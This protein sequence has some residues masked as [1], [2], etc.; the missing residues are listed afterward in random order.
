MKTKFSKFAFA[1]LALALGIGIMPKGQNLST[2]SYNY[3]QNIQNNN[4]PNPIDPDP[5][6]AQLDLSLF[7]NTVGNSLDSIQ[8]GI[9]GM[10]KSQKISKGLSIASFSFQLA[11]KIIVGALKAAG[12]IKDPTTEYLKAI[13]EIVQEINQQV[14]EINNKIDVLSGQLKK[15]F[16]KVGIEFAEQAIRTDLDILSNFDNNKLNTFVT[17]LQISINSMLNSFCDTGVYD[18]KASYVF[19]AALVINMDNATNKNITLDANIV[20]N[21]VMTVNSESGRINLDDPQAWFDKVLYKVYA[22]YLADPEKFAT[23]E[24]EYAREQR[25]D[26]GYKDETF[27]KALSNGFYSYLLNEFFTKICKQDDGAFVADLLSSYNDYC[28]GLN[29]LSSPVS[30]Q[31]DIIEHAFD[32]QGDT[33]Y[34]DSYGNERSLILDIGNFYMYNVVK[35]ASLALT[36][37]V[38]SG[39]CDTRTLN[40]I[41][42]DSRITTNNILSKMKAKYRVDKDG[43]PMDNYCYRLSCPVKVVDN[44]ITT[45][46]DENFVK[47]DN[48]TDK[49]DTVDLDGDSKGY[50]FG[51][52]VINKGDEGEMVGGEDLAYLS[53]LANDFHG[54]T[55][56]KDYLS[57]ILKKE[58]KTNIITSFDGV[59]DFAAKNKD[60]L[61]NVYQFGMPM[62]GRMAYQNPGESEG[63]EHYQMWINDSQYK[64][65]DY[66]LTDEDFLVHQQVS[67]SYFDVT[68]GEIM[69]D[70]SLYSMAFYYDKHSHKDDIGV[71][72]Q[73][74][75]AGGDFSEATT[76]NE[77]RFA[78]NVAGTVVYDDG[79]MVI[80]AKEAT[81]SGSRTK[82][83]WDIKFNALLQSVVKVTGDIYGEW[84]PTQAPSS[85]YFSSP[86][87]M[88]IQKAIDNYNEDKPEAAKLLPLDDFT[89]DAKYWIAYDSSEYD[90]EE[91]RE[92]LYDYAKELSNIQTLDNRYKAD[93][94]SFIEKFKAVNGGADEIVIDGGPSE[95]L[96]NVITSRIHFLE[97][98]GID[99]KGFEY[100]DA[101]CHSY[102]LSATPRYQVGEELKIAGAATDVVP[103]IY[104]SYVIMPSLSYTDGAGVAKRFELPIEVAS[105]LDTDNFEVNLP[106][107]K[108]DRSK[109]GVS[110]KYDEDVAEIGSNKEILTKEVSTLDDTDYFTVKVPNFAAF[111]LIEDAN[112][113]VYTDFEVEE[114]KSPTCQEAGFKACYKKNNLHYALPNE[115]SLINDY[116]AWKTGAGKLDKILH[117]GKVGG[118]TCAAD[119]T[120]TFTVK[121]EHCDYSETEDLN[122]IFVEDSPAN[123]TDPIKGH[124]ITFGRFTSGAFDNSVILAAKTELG[125]SDK[126]GSVPL[127]HNLQYRRIVSPTCTRAGIDEHYYCPDCK[128]Y[129]TDPDGANPVDP[130]TL[131]I[132]A[133]GHEMKYVPAKPATETEPGNTAYYYCTHCGGFFKDE[134]GYNSISEYEVLIKPTSYKYLPYEAEEP[135]HYKSGHKAYYYCPDNK[136]YYLDNNGYEEITDITEWLAPDGAGYLP[137]ESCEFGGPVSYV[138]NDD[139]C[140]A[141]HGCI[142]PGCKE[143]E[144]ETVDATFIV[145]TPATCTEDARGHYI[146]EFTNP[147]FGTYST[148]ANSNVREGTALGHKFDVAVPTW[149]GKFCTITGTCEHCHKSLSFTK[150]GTLVIDT[151]ATCITD[152]KGHYEVSFDNLHI[153]TQYTGI[154]N[155]DNSALGHLFDNGECIRC[156]TKDG[157]GANSMSLTGIIL[158]AVGCSLGAAVLVSVTQY[159]SNNKDKK[160]KKSKKKK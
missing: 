84:E 140:T 155:I 37:A 11:S 45:G 103:S 147:E 138:I 78:G 20:K 3:L 29:S 57:N 52:L 77:D 104:S 81:E 145:D 94:S 65:K 159:L 33:N 150:E 4:V 131:I 132:P 143:V 79:N 14:K 128:H 50:H 60:H 115:E 156:H 114:G 43:N 40:G 26:Y 160:S 119:G 134:H 98:H 92:T 108:H 39:N 99:I 113:E 130:L 16:A 85:P 23:S 42:E 93:N 66:S 87:T 13:L 91:E 17:K 47:T 62:D 144:Q 25:R 49:F 109:N 146:A 102:K 120:F 44:Y 151:P 101:H 36:A 107:L 136:T 1:S 24:L 31:Y 110:F 46:D 112:K 126:P 96:I 64:G 127:G 68:T 116:E 153:G 35:F 111:T 55:N 148:P 137:K 58:V 123:C 133:T 141:S 158:L 157:R 86:Q 7:T 69:E 21:A 124:Y 12:V 56:F 105:I 97:E 18:S 27:P 80:T 106:L 129:F 63:Y 117:T 139:K 72:S 28:A 9:K 152:A 125:S 38:A 61:M 67:G 149:N 95:D 76:F 90:S 75:L 41:A 154:F 135:T 2:Q 74:Y 121:C 89:N 59:E 71:F 34:V 142:Y 122:G 10:Q 53:I 30:C 32:F 70:E 83:T 22:T 118:H 5:A 6:I 8:N 88:A 19:D 15:D 54:I 48:T 82:T 51:T 73:S 100:P